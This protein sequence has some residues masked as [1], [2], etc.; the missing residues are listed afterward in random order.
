MRT[1]ISQ[2]Y[3]DVPKLAVPGTIKVLRT[4]ENIIISLSGKQ[5]IAGLFQFHSSRSLFSGLP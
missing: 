2:I 1:E 4:K 5:S 3:K